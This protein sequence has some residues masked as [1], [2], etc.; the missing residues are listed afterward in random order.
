MQVHLI[1]GTFELFRCFFGAPRAQTSDGREVGAV[2]GLLRTMLAQLNQPDCTHVAV[3]FDRVIE[4]FRNDLF[5]GYKTGAGL[6]VGLLEQFPIAEQAMRSLGLVV[7]PMV[8]FE[9]DDA[10]ATGAVRYGASADRVVLCSPDKDLAQCVRGDRIVLYDRMRD[11]ELDETG[12]QAKYGVPPGSIP[13]WL[14]LVGDPA[15]GIP[16]IPR[17]GTKSSATLLCRYHHIE[18]IP[19]DPAEWDVKVRGAAALAEQLRVHRGEAELYRTLATLCVDVPL[20]QTLEQLAWRGADRELL[21]DLCARIEYE[22]FLERVP[23]FSTA[24]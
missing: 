2:R 19:D 18:D 22:R 1:D 15:D 8:R 14:A 7:W 13:D 21:S 3:A 23:R 9:A 16:G 17:W 4:S 6:E 20:P 12:V 5:E 11:R 24:S 10:L